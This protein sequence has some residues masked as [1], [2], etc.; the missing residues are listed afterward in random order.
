M[1]LSIRWRLAA[2]IV[3]A[4][5]LTLAIIFITVQF[6]LQRILA[7]NL[8]DSLGDAARLMQARILVAGSLD[9][10]RLDDDVNQYANAREGSEPFITV[11]RDADGEVEAKTDN[12]Q[13]ESLLLSEEERARVLT[14][15]P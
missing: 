4:F 1:H 10:P 13:A 5:I 2:G 14:A 6:A 15:E 12:V 7:D 3:F 11:I 9:N 8:D